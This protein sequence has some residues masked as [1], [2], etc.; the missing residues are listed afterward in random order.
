MPSELDWS[1]H[2]IH[3][4]IRCKDK[5]SLSQVP[6][7]VVAVKMSAGHMI[8]ST[9][10]RRA[11]HYPS[12]H[13]DLHQP[14]TRSLNLHDTERAI[15]RLCSL[16]YSLRLQ[17]LRYG[18]YVFRRVDILDKCH[19]AS[20]LAAS[21]CRRISVLAVKNEALATLNQNWERALDIG[22]AKHAPHT[23]PN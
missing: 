5:E 6:H 2:Q 23:H 17:L 18:N 9:P 14:P 19:E 20:D 12:I 22:Y 10:T 11:I 8:G 3:L 7:I 13:C 4:D 21:I 15:I 16:S 1:A